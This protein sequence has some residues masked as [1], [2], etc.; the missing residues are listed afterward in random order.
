M[1]MGKYDEAMYELQSIFKIEPENKD[2]KNL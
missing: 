2:A 1:N